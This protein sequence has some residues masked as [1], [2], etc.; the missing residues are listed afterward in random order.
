MLSFFK[1]LLELW[2]VKG[3]SLLHTSAHSCCC[4]YVKSI[5]TNQ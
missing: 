4:G 3:F 1:T 5:A 2:G